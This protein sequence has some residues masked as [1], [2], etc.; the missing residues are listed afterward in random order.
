MSELKELSWEV[1]KTVQ[2]LPFETLRRRGVRRRRRRQ[3]LTGAGAAAAVAIAVLA[4]MLPLG[5]VTG[6]EKPPVAGTPTVIPVDQA[7]EKL[8]ADK[9]S[10]SIAIAFGT[11]TRWASVW[12]SPAPDYT[13]DSVAVLSRD[14][15]RATTPVRKEPWR[16]LQAGDEALALALPGDLKEGDPRWSQSLMVRLTDQG[17]IEKQLSWA[18]PTSEFAA[19]DVLLVQGSLQALNPE[20]GKLREVKIPGLQGAGQ[21]QR[22]TTG[23]WW[24]M[25]ANERGACTVYW[26][27]DNGKSWDNHVVDSARPR[28]SLGVSPDGRTLVAYPAR[29][30][31]APDGA[32]PVQLSTDRGARWTTVVTRDPTFLSD[33]VAF[34]DGTALLLYQGKKRELLRPGAGAPLA[35]P[36]D[37][38]ELKSLGGLVYASRYHLGGK[39]T[40]AMT[41]ADHGVTWK[42]FEPR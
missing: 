23:R 18:P 30:F 25:G 13:Y 2:P 38:G 27:D 11:P 6:T 17:R 29:K 12:S 5:D 19:D 7:A 24:L 28:G 37:L 31:D 33:P 4:V 1:Q 32:V 16:V 14:G 34:D 40:Q 3:A 9:K 41:S 10:G 26:T 8:L 22:D 39:N 20:T 36:A 35:P 42:Y 15:V 21:P